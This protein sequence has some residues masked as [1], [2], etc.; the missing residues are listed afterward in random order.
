MQLYAGQENYPKNLTQVIIYIF[1]Y[2]RIAVIK[3]GKYGA[4]TYNK[5]GTWL[6]PATK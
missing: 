6:K 2:E 3:Y 4:N 1:S 5:E